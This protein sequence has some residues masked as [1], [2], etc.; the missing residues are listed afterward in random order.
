MKYDN[1]QRMNCDVFNAI[2]DGYLHEIKLYCRSHGYK[3]VLPDTL[4]GV[5]CFLF[6]HKVVHRKEYTHAPYCS[7]C[8]K[9]LLIN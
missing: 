9:E 6:G 1:G 8:N 5:I 3:Y 7:R 2:K 4:K